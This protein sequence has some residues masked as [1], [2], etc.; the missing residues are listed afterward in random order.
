MPLPS[1]FHARTADLCTSLAWQTWSGYFAPSKYG[2]EHEREYL[3]IRH[4]VA[5]IDISPLHKLD[6]RGVDAALFLA[7]TTSRDITRLGLGRC[8]CLCWCDQDG[9]LVDQGILTRVSEQHFRLTSCQ[10]CLDWFG[11][12]TS[13]L[14]VE[15]EDT[16]ATLAA[17]AVQ[18]P[19]ARDT[20]A[21]AL[22]PEDQL[23][24]RRL[25]FFG[26]MQAQVRGL[27]CLI[28]RTGMTGDL[29]Y[30]LWTGIQNAIDLWDAVADAGFAYSLIPAG[31]M[32]LDMTRIE[33]GLLAPG[34][35]YHSSRDALIPSQRYSPFELGLGWTVELERELF[36]GQAA[37]IA[38][39]ASG[40]SRATV[41]LLI[42]WKELESLYL[43]AGLP[44]QLPTSAWRG[45]VPLYDQQNQQVGRATSGLWSPTLSQN[46]A[47]GLVDSA[48]ATLG[49]SLAIEVLVDDRRHRVTATVCP[50]PSFNPVRKKYTPDIG[51]QP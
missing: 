2:T 13:N 51:V 6:L 24:L 29:G 38:A 37:L 31:L 11:S 40:L 46:L 47:L 3:A 23:A 44:A 25:P 42:D 10:P 8:T 15:L 30:E 32:A 43:Q 49:T 39:G 5:V 48:W 20:V 12:Q 50:R 45:A 17:L 1:P 33:A 9:K 16:S 4:T 41:G 26:C 19:K 36:A 21:E 35:D 27:E 22:A 7:R 14:D 18:G 28:T 34:V